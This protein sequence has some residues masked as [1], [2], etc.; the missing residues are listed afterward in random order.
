[1]GPKRYRGPLIAAEAVGETF[2]TE[3]D[4]KLI[5]DMAAGTGRVGEEV[6]TAVP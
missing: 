6:G 1:M 4:S 3:R 2:P 5:I